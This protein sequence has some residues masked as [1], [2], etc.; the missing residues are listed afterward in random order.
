MTRVLPSRSS[1]VW[2][3]P[4]FTRVTPQTLKLPARRHKRKEKTNSIQRGPLQTEIPKQDTEQPRGINKSWNHTTVSWNKRLSRRG[5]E[6][7]PHKDITLGLRSFP[8]N[9]FQNTA[10]SL[11][12]WRSFISLWQYAEEMGLFSRRHISVPN[13]HINVFNDVYRRL[14]HAAL[15][16]LLT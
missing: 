12:K 8:F 15:S 7:F 3:D 2:S 1:H 11:R 14:K 5:H 9:T 16:S 13:L 4:H 10:G 6:S